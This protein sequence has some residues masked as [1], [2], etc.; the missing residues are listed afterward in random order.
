[1]SGSTLLPSTLWS[2]AGY[3]SR[4]PFFRTVVLAIVEYADLEQYRANNPTWPAGSGRMLDFP[5]PDFGKSADWVRC[6]SPK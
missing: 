3:E 2:A 4:Q 1:M 6:G 5:G